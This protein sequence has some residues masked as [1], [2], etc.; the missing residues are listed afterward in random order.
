MR[1][2]SFKKVGRDWEGRRRE[3]GSIYTGMHPDRDILQ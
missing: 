1:A 3:K 2:K